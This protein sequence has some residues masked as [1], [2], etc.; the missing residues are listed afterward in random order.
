MLTAPLGV[1]SGYCKIAKRTQ[2]STRGFCPLIPQFQ[3]KCRHPE[4]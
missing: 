1:L 3:R 2:G 4:P